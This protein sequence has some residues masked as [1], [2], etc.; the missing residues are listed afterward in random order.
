MGIER[1]SATWSAY[2]GVSEHTSASR[3]HHC[4]IFM[5]VHV[6]RYL[7]MEWHLLA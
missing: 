4:I 6:L 2:I 7:G 5:G 3:R 1:V